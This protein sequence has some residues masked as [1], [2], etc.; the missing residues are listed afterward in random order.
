MVAILQ[1]LTATVMVD[2]VLVGL[3]FILG[4]EKLPVSTCIVLGA[5]ATATAPA[6]TVMV[7]NQ[8]KARG[9]LTDIL[10]PIVALDDAVGLVV[11]A[12]SNGIAKALSSGQ[13]SIVGVIVNPLLEIILSV[14]LG[15]LLGWVFSLVEKFFNS[16]SKRLSLAVAFVALS[17]GLAKLEIPLG[18]DLE[19]GFSS[20]LVCMMCG[21]V[22][23]NLCD[24]S[25]EIMYKTDKWTAPVNV[26]FFVLSG[27]SWT[28]GCSVTW[29]LLASALLTSWPGPPVKFWVPLTAPG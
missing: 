14:G 29:L 13:I 17:A 19:I 21:T 24:F 22:F 8:Y 2:L 1:A 25:E 9:P 10:L 3:H 5:I 11:F 27:A 6:A 16:N 23:C 28:C 15:A 18:G 26:L 12:V 20:L 7:I 4:P